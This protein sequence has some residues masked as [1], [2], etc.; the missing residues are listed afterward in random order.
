MMMNEEAAGGDWDYSVHL[1]LDGRKRTPGCR[2]KLEISS[3]CL[4]AGRFHRN[5]A[6]ATKEVTFEVEGYDEVAKADMG[7]I[8]CGVRST[9]SGW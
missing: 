1:I 8:K 7:G 9:I 6:S 3:G 2:W 5:I 4:S